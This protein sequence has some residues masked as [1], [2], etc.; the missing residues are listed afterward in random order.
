MVIS[1]SPQLSFNIHDLN[2]IDENI[3]NNIAMEILLTDKQ[4]VF[5]LT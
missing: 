5:L 4:F 2:N 3:M 1:Y